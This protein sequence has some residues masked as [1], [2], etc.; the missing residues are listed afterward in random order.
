MA[1]D[2][3]IH[4]QIETLSSYTHNFPIVG[5]GASAGGVEAFKELLQA[6]PPASNMAYV[7]VQHLSPDHDSALTEILSRVT[8]IPIEE[9]TDEVKILPDHIYV[10]P[11]GKILTSVDGV[12]KLTPRDGVKTNLVIDIFFSSIAVV[13]ESMAVG[14]VLS[15]TGADGTLGLKMI[16]E[17]G[18]ITIVQDESAEYDSMPQS[19]VDAEVVDFVLP[20]SKIPAQL[21]KINN[22]FTSAISNGQDDIPT[23]NDEI[24][25]KQILKLLQ[26][27]SGVDFTYYKQTTVSR[28]IGRRMALHQRGDLADYLRFLSSDIAEQD[29]LFKDM[30]IHVTAFFRD[31]KTFKTLTEKVLPA[32]VDGKQ[33]E[34]TIRIWIAGCSTGEEAYSIAICLHEYLKLNPSFGGRGA[35]QIF[36]SDVSKNAIKKARAGI[37]SKEEIKTISEDRLTNYFT[38]TVGGYQVNKVIRDMCV[39]ANHNFLKD[40]PFARIDLLTCRNVLIYMDASLQKK[41][42]TTFHYALKENGTLLLGKSETVTAAAVLFN[43]LDKQHKL[44]TRKQ[45]AGRFM[46]VTTGRKEETLTKQNTEN[47]NEIVQTDFRISANA[48]LMSKSPA[49]VIINEALDIVHFHGDISAF[50]KPPA[51]K[52]SFNIIKMARVELALELRNAINKIKIQKAPVNKAEIHIKA[53]GKNSLIT[54][55][56][57]PLLD[58][59]EPHYLVLF[60]KIDLPATLSLL[61][62][63]TKSIKEKGS[64]SFAV[65]NERVNI[66]EKELAHTQEG[67]RSVTEEMETANEAL[68]SVNEELQSSIEEMQ[69]LNEELETSKEELQ[70]SN[71]E[72]IS[73]NNELIK[74][75]EHLD[76]SLDY[77]EAIVSTV[78]EPLIVL[79]NNLRIKSANSSFYKKFNLAKGEIQG[80]FFFEIQK[81]QWKNIE[82]RN[83]LESILPNTSRMEDFEMMLDERTMLLNARE[84]VSE[85]NKEQLI[86]LGIVDITDSKLAKKLRLSET[87]FRHVIMQ[88][89]VAIA[90]FVGPTFIIDTVNKT[91]LQLWGKSYEEVISKPVFEVSLELEEGFKTILNDIYH[92]GIPFNTKEVPVQIKRPGKPDLAYFT[93]VYEPLRD[94]NDKI[95]GIILILTEVTEAV[96]ARKMIE[97]SEAFNRTILESSPDCLKVLDPE[98]R[99]QFMNSNGLCQ[100][101]IDD[102]STINNKSWSTLWGFENEPLVKASIDKALRGEAAHFTAFCAT[103]KGTPKWWD[104]VVTPVGQTDEPVQRIISVSRDIT[105]QKEAQL[106]VNASEEKYRDL[107]ESI[108]QGLSIIE[109]IFDQNNKPIDYRFIENNMVF[110]KQTGLPDISGKTVSEVIPDLEDFWFETYGTVALTGKPIRFTQYAEG[111]NNWFDVYAFRLGEEESKKVAILFT[112]ITERI[113]VEEKTKQNEEKIRNFILQAPV[114]MALY[115]GPKFVVEIVNEALLN[116]WDKSLDLVYN[117]PVFEA[118]SEASNQGFEALFDNVYKTEEKFTAFGIPIIMPRNGKPETFYVNVVYQPYRNEDG[119]IY[120]IVEVVSDVTEQVMAVKKLEQSENQFRTFA[121]SIQNLA[122]IANGD[123]QIYWY[124]KQWYDYTGTTVKEMEGWGWQKV[125]HPD[126]V[127]N[128][129]ELTTEF[130]KKDEPFELTFPLRRHDGEY[131]WFLTRAYPVIDTNGNIERWIGTNTD[132]TE[133]K[134]FTEELERKVKE[135]TIELEERKK[136][137]ETVLETSKECIA[138]YGKDLK[139]ITINKATEILMGQKREDVVGKTLLELI[140]QSKGSREELQLKSALEGNNIYNEPYRSSI[141]GRYIENYINPLRDE[142]GNVYAAVAM[143]NDVTSI[144]MRQKEIEAAKEL[145]QIQNQTFQLAESVAKFVSYKWNITGNVLE[146]SASLF[147]LL[148]CEPNEFEPSLEKFTSFIHPDDLQQVIKNREET[149]KTGVLVETPYRIISK[150]GKIKHLRSSGSFIGENEHRFLIGTV[151]DISKDVEAAEDLRTKNLELEFTNAELASFTYIASHDLQ[152]PLR[153]IQTFSK[154]IVEVEKFSEQTQDYFNR[155]IASSER[156]QSL[157]ISLL[158]FSQISSTKVV[159]E[160]CNLNDIIEESVDNLQLSIT[161]KQVLVEFENLPTINGSQIQLSQLFTNLIENAIKYSRQE[162]TPH[163]KIKS[164]IVEGKEIDHASTNIKKKYHKIIVADNGIGFKE[165]YEKKI[166]ELFQ[167]LHSKNEYSGTG[168]G[169]SIVK[170]IVTKHNGFI[171]AKGKPGVGSTFSIYIPTT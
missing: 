151:Q 40:P 1:N 127:K 157:I 143:A 153:K 18:G 97:A 125:H 124:N 89:P 90:T 62:G 109:M 28:R 104:V 133:Q 115:R 47:K 69:S 101:E 16:K 68:Q 8:K 78:K 158:D 118:M 60:T 86:L 167:R 32:L 24:V 165:E 63:A 169:L 162:T 130:W 46:Q 156:M 51:G 30:L 166:F 91:A 85:K 49:G 26:Q 122:W 120:G 21:L 113:K 13:W 76:A 170:K 110:H 123:G 152:E 70:S 48:I 54:I 93:S 94:L 34:E 121:D 150:K 44:Y 155:I 39:F 67:M 33:D 100:M 77:S 160:P 55:E 137:V 73:L 144:I 61:K 92:T 140:P 52:P 80:L 106:K 17:H 12:L 2:I 43:N 128:I 163:I 149:I 72:L 45:G 171:V 117:K 14:V 102:F 38:K 42:L 66:L 99:I 138:V 141:T 87:K 81:Q 84:I 114:A 95:Y 75:Q 129:V 11:E 74:K 53:D 96:N 10:M 146:Y 168:I 64:I 142:A 4:G 25:L 56:I 22:V 154:R 23:Q 136:F 119:T 139:I 83:M 132:I 145:L 88:A 112:N 147:R 7:V 9:I 36:A 59:A 58:T 27:R 98:G 6:I 50:L 82:L 35:V 3:E 134:T 5:I 164:Y 29:A 107:F 31:A 108:D 19:A 37:Y 148:D 71:E 131:R 15:G 41:A 103:T 126:H 111:L 161:E 79:D 159:F 135:R 116:F 105:E 65:E 57:I 20:A